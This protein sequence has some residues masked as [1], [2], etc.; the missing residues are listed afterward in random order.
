MFYSAC[1]VHSR[2]KETFSEFVRV[3]GESKEI[4]F[5]REIIWLQCSESH[6]EYRHGGR[7]L[8]VSTSTYND[9]Y[10]YLTSMDDLD[11]LKVAT[12]YGIDRT[13]TLELVVVTKVVLSPACETDA[14][15]ERNR[16][17]PPSYKTAYEYVPSEWRRPVVVDGE[18]IWPPIQAR[19]LGEEVTWSSKNTPEENAALLAA[20][21]TRWRFETTEREP[22]PA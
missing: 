18:K 10:G 21:R 12:S 11:Q 5:D 9:F 19:D 6:L 20:F 16:N 7:A 17:A 22:V 2:V 4:P 13:S 1:P 15:A 8:D 3:G 14:T